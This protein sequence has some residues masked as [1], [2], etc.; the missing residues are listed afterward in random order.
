M[1]KFFATTDEIVKGQI[2]APLNVSVIPNHM[3][4]NLCAVEGLSWIEQPDGQ[5]VSLTIHFNPVT[6]ENNNRVKQ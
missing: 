1:K 4:I 6:K 5:L 2:V 3:G